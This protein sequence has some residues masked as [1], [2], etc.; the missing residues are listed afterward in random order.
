MP[1]GSMVVINCL[2]VCISYMHAGR[3]LVEMVC[4]G[5]QYQ[6]Q[7]L[8]RKAANWSRMKFIMCVCISNRLYPIIYGPHAVSLTYTWQWLI[9]TLLHCLA[10]WVYN[11]RRHAA[12]SSASITIK[13]SHML[14][15]HAFFWVRQDCL[16]CTTYILYCYVNIIVTLVYKL[17][18]CKYYV[19][20]NP[21]Y[22][23]LS[24]NLT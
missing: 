23:Q 18:W 20:K 4:S 11:Y 1:L 12:V 7:P 16:E 3:V 5:F 24:N 22:F 19:T 9:H 14:R 8:I 13:D 2:C 17:I 10:L 15:F 21:N 6:S